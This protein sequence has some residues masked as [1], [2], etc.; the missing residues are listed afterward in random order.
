M[1]YDFKVLYR[2]GAM[3]TIADMFASSLHGDIAKSIRIYTSRSSQC[4]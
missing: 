3:N 4:S 1:E 2:K